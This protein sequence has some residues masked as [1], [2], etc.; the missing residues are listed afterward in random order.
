VQRVPRQKRFREALGWTRSETLF[1]TKRPAARRLVGHILGTTTPQPP[2]NAMKRR[3]P[4]SLSCR[5]IR[6]FG[7]GQRAGATTSAG[8]RADEPCFD[9]QRCQHGTVAVVPGG[10]RVPRMSRLASDMTS[11]QGAERHGEC[12]GNY[13]TCEALGQVTRDPP[14][15][16]ENRQGCKLLAGSNVSTYKFRKVLQCQ[17]RRRPGA[18]RVGPAPVG[19]LP[20][21]RRRSMDASDVQRENQKS[22]LTDR[23]PGPER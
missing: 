15:D 5:M 9:T 3:E 16:L 4:T 22:F 18:A 2:R 21:R 1:G 7:Q 6:S 17:G 11:L 10:N 14:G 19:E 12:A 13:V 8:C 20:G 23:T